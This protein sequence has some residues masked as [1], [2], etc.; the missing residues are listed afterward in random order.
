MASYVHIGILYVANDMVTTHVPIPTDRWAVAPEFLTITAGDG[1]TPFP[2]VVS[3]DY[4]Q[5][6][7]LAWS[8]T[9]DGDT[10]MLVRFDGEAADAEG[11]YVPAGGSREFRV[12]HT[13]VFPSVIPVP[14]VA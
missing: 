3:P 10:S 11:F 1:A 7:G 6:L 5:K 12:T 9:V 4:A 2:S 8:V 14:D 13:G